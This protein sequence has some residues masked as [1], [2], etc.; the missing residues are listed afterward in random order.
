MSCPDDHDDEDERGGLTPPP[1]RKAS[2]VLEVEVWS[3]QDEDWR[4]CILRLDHKELLDHHA[5]V[6]WV[7]GVHRYAESAREIPRSTQ[8]SRW[9]WSP[10][11]I[12]RTTRTPSRCST[13]TGGVRPDGCR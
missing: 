5:F 1:R 11:P 3:H 6:A 10:I 12:I 4:G 7:A 8:A 13:P 2:S 9:S